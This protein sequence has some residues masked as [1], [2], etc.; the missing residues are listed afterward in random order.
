MQL[1]PSFA[2]S[3]LIS[4]PPPPPPLARLCLP[5]PHRKKGK[6]KGGGHFCSEGLRLCWCYRKCV[7]KLRHRP[8][9]L[10]RARTHQRLIISRGLGLSQAASNWAVAITGF[11][12]P[13]K[14]LKPE[15][16]S[17]LGSFAVGACTT[18]APTGVSF[19]CSSGLLNATTQK[20]GAS[21][22]L[23]CYTCLG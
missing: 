16:F 22:M 3:K 5:C 23:T 6:K 4:P 21:N 14:F 15:M 1:S 17:V 20:G 13:Q 19:L 12:N 7:V 9:Q 2:C 18:A 11:P 10:L 8:I